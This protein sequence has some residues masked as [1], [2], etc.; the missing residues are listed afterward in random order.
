MLDEEVSLRSAREKR[1]E[2]DAT[3]TTSLAEDKTLHSLD[4]DTEAS[5]AP[6][7]GPNMKET[8]RT[9]WMRVTLT[10]LMFS[11]FL[12]SSGML[13]GLRG[14]TMIDLAK[15]FGTEIKSISNIVTLGGS[16]GSIT[17]ATF[18]GFFLDRFERHTTVF[19]SL[20][21]VGAG[22]S[23]ALYTATKNLYVFGAAVISFGFCAGS[24]T[25]GEEN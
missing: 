15:Y 14:P 22:L 19:L 12:T 24:I 9:L 3:E 11:A 13:D 5:E 10:L 8:T 7:N 25:T 4:L 23:T 16:A 20:A 2:S 17:G 18:A 6:S 1:E 21:A